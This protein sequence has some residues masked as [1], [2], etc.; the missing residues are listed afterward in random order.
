M[1]TLT[2]QTIANSYK[3][4]LQVSNSN[5]GVDGTLRVVEDGEGTSSA[6]QISSS[7]VKSTGSLVV[8]GGSTLSG[9]TLSGDLIVNANIDLSGNIDVDGTLEADAITVNGASLASVIQGTTVTNA[10]NSTNATTSATVTTNANLTGHITSVGNSAVLGS[11]TLAQLNTALSDATLGGSSEVN[12][13]SASV[14]WANVPEANIPALPT[15]KI[16]SGTFADARIASSN[17]TQ[18]QASLSIGASQIGSGTLADARIAASNVTQHAVAK[19]GGA[20]SGAIYV[21]SNYVGHAVGMRGQNT[22]YGEGAR[23]SFSGGGGSGET[24]PGSTG[25]THI[26]YNSG[27]TDTSNN[28]FDHN[29]S[30]GANSLTSGAVAYGCVAIGYDSQKTN[31]NGRNLVSVGLKSME[32]APNSGS[33]SFYENVGIGS[34]ASQKGTNGSNNVAIGHQ[35]L[36]LAEVCA[37]NTAVGSNALK[38]LAQNGQGSS[39]N[40]NWDGNVQIGSW[41]QYNRVLGK[42]NTAIGYAVAYNAATG[43]NSVIIGHNSGRETNSGSSITSL[44]NSVVIGNIATC[45]TATPTNEIVIGYDAQGQGD[46]TV[47]MGNTSMTACKAQ[48]SWTTYSD[49]RIK[50]N[51]ASTDI[52]LAFIN[53]LNPVKYQPVNPADYPDAIKDRRFSDRTF[54]IGDNDNTVTADSRPA[55]DNGIRHGLIAQEVKATLDELGIESDIWNESSNGKQGIK[56]EAL[57]IPLIKAVQELSARVT[58]LEG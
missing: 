30:L 46:N 7:G 9:A 15:S 6:L 18:H 10:T 21:S 16:T 19:T 12:D 51:I 47:A 38:K 52:G 5:S 2:G 26:G 57:V 20:F 17:V 43:D 1:A 45:N 50:R 24:G 13:L 53:K 31:E 40:G 48:V 34:Y 3:D 39:G 49:S 27:G 23:N 36:Q 22:A 33:S 25:N 28:G 4:L 32:D 14:T 11:F 41:G 29:T 37:Y 55:D 58:T 35:S 54:K 44:D 8:A 56:Y 42:N